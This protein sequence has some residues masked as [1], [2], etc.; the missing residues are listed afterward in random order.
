LIATAVGPLQRIIISLEGR[1]RTSVSDGIV[2]G[3]DGPRHSSA[4]GEGFE[5]LS[6]LRACWRLGAS[7]GKAELLR[8]SFRSTLASTEKPSTEHSCEESSKPFANSTESTTSL[9]TDVCDDRR[10]MMLD[11]GTSLARL[12]VQRWLFDLIK[13]Y[14]TFPYCMRS[15]NGIM[16]FVSSQVAIGMSACE[17]ARW[18][19]TF[20][21]H[22]Y[23]TGLILGLTGFDALTS[24]SPIK[25]KTEPSVTAAVVPWNYSSPPSLRLLALPRCSDNHKATSK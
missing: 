16:S 25:I 19:S 3:I 2:A 7:G 15:C 14:C 10:F 1:F 9:R 6:D 17:I 22:R 12:I 18:T 13:R 21:R 5:D 11:D 24:T 4:F 8:A 23:R 20:R